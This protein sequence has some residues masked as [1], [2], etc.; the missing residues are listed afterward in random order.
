MGR[1]LC[2]GHGICTLSHDTSLNNITFVMPKAGLLQAHYFHIKGVFKTDF[3]DR[4]PVLFYYI[5]VPLTANLGTSL[6]TRLTNVAFNS[7]IELV[8]QDT[9]LLTVE[10]HPFHIY[11]FNFFVV[12]SGVGNFDPSKDPAKFNLV[13]PPERNTV[14]VPTRRW[15]TIRF[16]AIIRCLV[17]ALPPETAYDVGSKDGL[18]C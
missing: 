2:H 15:T 8:L 18:C 9:N 11:G 1:I 4:L 17:Y 13:N 10:S 5:G 12:G 14:G 3:L 7:T 6:G 16:R